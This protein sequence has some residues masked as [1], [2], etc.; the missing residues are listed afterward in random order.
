MNKQE[1]LK[2]LINLHAINPSISSVDERI[3]AEYARGLFGKVYSYIPDGEISGF[4]IDE[5]IMLSQLDK[6]KCI[7]LI[8]S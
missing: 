3:V 7:E 6:D 5:C 2:K 1:L 8:H 4:H